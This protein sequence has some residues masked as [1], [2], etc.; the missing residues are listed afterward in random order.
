MEILESELLGH[1]RDDPAL[2]RAAL[3]ATVGMS[4]FA[5]IRDLSADNL[6]R[7]RIEARDLRQVVM[8]DQGN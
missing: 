3:V 1:W 8:L 5:K 7:R 6:G 4:R 2:A